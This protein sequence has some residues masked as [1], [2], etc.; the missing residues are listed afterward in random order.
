[1]IVVSDA[2]PL[3]GLILI[4]KLQL[5]Q[6]IFQTIV[7]PPKVHGELLALEQFGHSITAF[8]AAD[9]IFV[10]HPTILRSCAI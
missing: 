9:W 7:I 6:Q 4:D 1:M 5:L 2:S 8:K 3:S 10:K